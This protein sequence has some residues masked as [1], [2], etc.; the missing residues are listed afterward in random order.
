MRLAHS[1]LTVSWI[2]IGT[3]IDSWPG[4]EDD[5]YVLRDIK[6][7]GKGS[8]RRGFRMLHRLFRDHS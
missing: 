8:H 1:Y 6:A 2:M 5:D 4:A 3:P 7:L